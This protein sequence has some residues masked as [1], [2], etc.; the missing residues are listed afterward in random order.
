MINLLS[1][2]IYIY[3]SF[4]NNH[5]L[6]WFVKGGG[7]FIWFLGEIYLEEGVKYLDYA[8]QLGKKHKLIS[9]FFLSSNLTTRDIHKRHILPFWLA[10]LKIR[11]I[12]GCLCLT[13]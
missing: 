11:N 1:I 3:I 2:Y 13:W 6:L 5:Q 8:G 9:F 7:R 12:E 10:P 4:D